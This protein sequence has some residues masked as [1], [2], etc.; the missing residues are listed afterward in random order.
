MLAAHTTMDSLQSSKRWPCILGTTCGNRTHKESALSLQALISPNHPALVEAGVEPKSTRRPWRPHSDKQAGPQ[1][2]L[3][4][5][6]EVAWV[7]CFRE[8]PGG[9]RRTLE[10]EDL[11]GVVL[12]T[13]GSGN[14]LTS[15]LLRDLLRSARDRGDARECHARG[16]VAFIL[17]DTPP[18]TCSRAVASSRDGT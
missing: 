8:C 15:Q 3:G 18:A 7:L 14:A 10:W 11:R 13:F 9:L 2:H 17:N 12:A 16:M 1:L 6:T 4:L 5:R